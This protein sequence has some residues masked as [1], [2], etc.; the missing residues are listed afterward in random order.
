M[1][2]SIISPNKLHED[3]FELLEDNKL[4]MVN[5]DNKDLI[6][7]HIE[8]YIKNSNYIQYSN[9]FDNADVLFDDICR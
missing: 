5:I 3:I 8:M 4:K 7:Y 1:N 2:Y 6:T 9:T